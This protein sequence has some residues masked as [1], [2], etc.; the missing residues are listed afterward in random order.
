MRKGTSS[1]YGAREL[2]RTIL[3]HLTQP[4][5]AMVESARSAGEGGCSQG[6]RVA[7]VDT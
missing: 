2:K 3:R 4:L 7:Q 6:R 1:E 5:A